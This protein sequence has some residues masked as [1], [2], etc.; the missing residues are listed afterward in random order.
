MPLEKRISTDAMAP[1]GPGRMLLGLGG[2][3]DDE[4]VWDGSLIRRLAIEHDLRIADCDPTL[5]IHDER[6]LLAVI[7]GFAREGRGGE[8]FVEA[9]EVIARFAAQHRKTVTLGGTCVR[10]ALMMRALGVRSTVH[11]VSIDDDFR[12]LYPRDCDYISSA[13]RDGMYPHLIVQLPEHDRISLADGEVTIATPNRLIFTNDPPHVSMVL[14]PDFA[15][16]A[17]A[18]EYVLVSGFNVMVD[19]ELVTARLADLRSALRA[20]PRSGVVMYEDAG[21]HDPRLHGLVRAEIASMVEVYSM[22][23]DEWQTHIGRDIDLLDVDDVARAL[24]S[25]RRLISTPTL[26][27]HTRHWALAY[28]ADAARYETALL[29]GTSAATARYVYGDAVTAQQV[30]A[31]TA[32]EAPAA[33]A[34]F[35]EQLASLVSEPVSCVSVRS[36]A[37]PRPTTIGLGDSFVGGF[38]AALAAADRKVIA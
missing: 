10:A 31:I 30:A 37:A 21:F 28:G 2:T 11:L 1:S 20:R 8:R 14:S 16:A 38:L 18:A 13:S 3:I 32:R 12:R 5:P 17:S 27:L 9:P 26:V 6:S 4:I 7:L 35:A 29:G 25:I 33:H 36:V 22:N 19:A 24:R 34:S 15:P 23:E